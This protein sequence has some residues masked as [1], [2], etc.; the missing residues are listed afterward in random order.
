MAGNDLTSGLVPHSWDFST[1]SVN[2]IIITPSEVSINANETVVLLAQAYDSQNNPIDDITYTWSLN[3]NLGTITSQDLQIASF[4]ASSKAGTC[5]VNVTAGG[6]SAGVMITIKPKEI[7]EEEPEDSK[8]E[9]LLWIWFLIIV[10]IILF[11]VNLWVALRKRA[12]ELKESPESVDEEATQ[13]DTVD[14]NQGA[15]QEPT[16]EAPPEP[17][18][19]LPSEPLPPPPEDL[20]EEIPPPPED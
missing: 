14:E 4:K 11:I 10:I 12:P 5:Y 20:S 1:I 9:D 13:K 6:K 15:A 16:P 19:E 7:V 2:S 18:S 3:N 17:S 8:P